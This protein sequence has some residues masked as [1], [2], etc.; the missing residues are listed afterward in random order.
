[1]YTGDIEEQLRQKFQR[2]GPFLN[3]K[4]RRLVVASEAM[5]LGYGGIAMAARATGLS[6]PTIRAGVGELAQP[7]AVPHDRIRRPGGGR[8]TVTDRDPTVLAD[9]DRLIAPATRGDPESPLRWTSKSLIKLATELQAMG[10]TISPNTVGILLRQQGYSLQSPRKVHE[11][12]G[13][14]PDRDG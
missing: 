14:H 5:A 4:V 9:L 8:K 12:A 11:G 13:D 7:D 1:M 2:V 6:E 3:E 10:H